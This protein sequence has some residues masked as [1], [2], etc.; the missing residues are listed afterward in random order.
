MCALLAGNIMPKLCL[1]RFVVAVRKIYKL[2][3]VSTSCFA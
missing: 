3:A 1:L 2:D